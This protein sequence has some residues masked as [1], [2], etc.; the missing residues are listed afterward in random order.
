MLP[1]PLSETPVDVK[2]EVRPTGNDQQLDIFLLLFE[3]E[4]I[5]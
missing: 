5:F 2:E 3:I 1:E 4:V